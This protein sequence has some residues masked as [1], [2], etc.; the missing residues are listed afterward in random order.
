MTVSK[1]SFEC[2]SEILRDQKLL[3]EQRFGVAL[4]P[5]N[6]FNKPVIEDSNACCGETKPTTAKIF[7][8]Q[9]S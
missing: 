9:H 1:K 6:P 2:L 4:R 8:D 7:V 5:A 3:K